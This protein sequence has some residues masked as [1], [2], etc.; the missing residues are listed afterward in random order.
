MA[1]PLHHDPTDSRRE[2]GQHFS[3]SGVLRTLPGEQII[4]TDHQGVR[5]GFRATAAKTLCMPVMKWDWNDVQ[6]G[7]PD[8]DSLSS[9]A[10]RMKNVPDAVNLGPVRAH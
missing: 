1:H 7:Q 4:D 8:C 5:L 3:V 6:H 9:V 10:S 2:T